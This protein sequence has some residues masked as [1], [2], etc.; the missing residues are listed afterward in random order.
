APAAAHWMPRRAFAGT[1]DEE[2]RRNRAPY[3]PTDFDRRFF[4]CAAPELTF[5]RY[6]QGGEPVEV[7]GA[8]PDGPIAFLLPVGGIQLHVT[9]DGASERPPPHLETVLIEPDAN[10]MCMTWRAV[11][12][13]DRKSLKISK[14]V[15]GRA[16]AGARA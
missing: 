11:L 7:Q 5:D 8:T 10:R 13:C 4:Q 9:V 1:Y 6:L 15:I 16:R 3:L 14:V 2:W 12:P